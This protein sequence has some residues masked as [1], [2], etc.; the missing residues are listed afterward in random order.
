MGETSRTLG[1]AV[2]VVLYLSV[3]VMAAAGCVAIG[4]RFLRPKQEEVFYGGFLV[5]IAAFYLAFAAY[6]QIATAWRME[7]FAFLVFAGVGVVGARI[8]A[9][10]IVGY[11]LHGL[12]D[13]VHELQ[14]HG[15]WSAFASGEVTTVSARLRHLLRRLRSVHCRLRRPSERGVERRLARA[16]LIRNSAFGSRTRR[17]ALRERAGWRTAH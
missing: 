1:F 4:R 9:L 17:S 15:A 3:G 6:F 11:S 12:W 16:R 2:I 8:P 13:L 5:L 10:L 7:S 14:Q